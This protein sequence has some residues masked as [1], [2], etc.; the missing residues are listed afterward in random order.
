LR[1]SGWQIAMLER[2]EFFSLHGECSAEVFSAGFSEKMVRAMEFTCGQML[3]AAYEYSYSGGQQVTTVFS[4][5]DKPRETGYPPVNMYDPSRVI[6]SLGLFTSF[7]DRLLSQSSL[8]WPPLVIFTRQANAASSGALDTMALA[9]SVAVEGLLLSEFANFRPRDH[10][11]LSTSVAHVEAIIE[12]DSQLTD[13]FKRRAIGAL[14]ALK[15]IRAGDI[16]VALEEQARLPAGAQKAWSKLRNR[17]AHPRKQS[18]TNLLEI[19]RLY[20]QC[21]IVLVLLYRLVFI[22]LGYKGPYIDYSTRNWPEGHWPYNP[23]GNART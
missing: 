4:C 16:L 17:H 22:S 5:V 7:L 10:Q 6:W 21:R 1:G 12:G 13:T 14:G 19:D 9:V 2:T 20:E 8:D 15:H 18:N 3:Q 11:D 23:D